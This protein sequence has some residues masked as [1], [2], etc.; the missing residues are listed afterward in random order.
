MARARLYRPSKSAMTSGMRNTR[1]WILEFE[2]EKK[3]EIEPL[4]GWTSSADTLSQI[5][6]RFPTKEEALAYAK[7]RK[8]ECE[9]LP[10]HKRS[11]ILKS[12]AD[13]FR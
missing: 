1:N 2:P 4:M 3:R 6:L 5:R 7:S 8:I 10:E 12:Y 11:R 9:I 13:N